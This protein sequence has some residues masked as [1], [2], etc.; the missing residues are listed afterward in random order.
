MSAEK[1]DEHRYRTLAI[2][3][4]AGAAIF[5]GALFVLLFALG[6]GG[7]KLDSS[8]NYFYLLMAGAGGLFGLERWMYHESGGVNPFHDR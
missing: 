2:F 3:L 8:V 7:Y 4:A 5:S 6:M 1:V